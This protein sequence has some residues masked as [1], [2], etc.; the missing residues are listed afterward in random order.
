MNSADQ[1]VYP[2]DTAFKRRWSIEFM[3]INEGVNELNKINAVV[4]YN[5]RDIAWNKLREAI[6]E[7]LQYEGIRE[8]K[9]IGPFFIGKKALKNE[10]MLNKS[11][12]NKLLMY[13]F[14]DVARHNKEIIFS[15]PYSSFSELVTDY[16]DGV[17]IFVIN[18]ENEEE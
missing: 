13:L 18:L 16:T 5:N 2:M 9:L 1:G 11:I 17:D 10:D 4:K 3:D 6:N 15:K 8:D 7:K 14:D 12:E